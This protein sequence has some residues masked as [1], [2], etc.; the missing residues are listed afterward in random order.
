MRV[1]RRWSMLCMLALI[2]T[3]ANAQKSPL[4][5]SLY[6]KA[7]ADSA[8]SEYLRSA[9]GFY[10]AAVEETKS[11]GYDAAFSAY[12]YYRAGFLFEALSKFE[13]AHKAYHLS[14]PYFRKAGKELNVQLTLRIIGAL[15]DKSRKKGIVYDFP[16]GPAQETINATR[17]IDSLKQLPDKTYEAVIDGGTN[18]GIYEGADAEVY[19]KHISGLD[20]SNRLLGSARITEVY[21][22]YS[23]AVIQLINPA[24]SFYAIYPKD[25]ITVPIR[26]PKLAFKDVFLEVSLMNIRFVDN[27]REWIAH[28]RTMMYYPSQELEKDIYKCML[29]AIEEIYEMIKDDTTYNPKDVITRGRLKGITWKQAMSRSTPEDLKAFLGFVR[30]YPGKYMG[31]VWK[32]SETY[33][34]WLLNNAPPGS[35]EIMDSLMAAKTDAEFL[36]YAKSYETSIRDNF[37]TAWQVDAQNMAFIDRFDEALKWNK[38]LQRVAGVYNDPDMIGWSLFN[39]GRIQDE[40]KKYDDALSSYS[41]AKSYFEKGKD[42]RGLSFCINNLG[43]I[44]GVKYM[45]KESELMYEQVLKLRL[46]R[47]LQDS[48]DEQR[49][50]VARAYWGVGDALYNQS[51]YKEAIDQY[52]KGLAVLAKARSLEARKQTATINRLMG[53]SYEKM[54]DYQLAADCYE[55][56]FRYQKALGDVEAEADAVDN[57]AYLLSKVGKYRDAFEKY[58]L[59]YELHL[60]SGEKND[61]GFSMSNIGQVLWSLGKFDSAIDA[62]NRAI[63]LRREIGNLKGEAYSW[64]KIGALYKESGDATRSM[65]AYER[66]LGLYK[67]SEAREEY[68]ELLEDIASN[69]VKIK[70][71]SNADKYYQQALLEYRSIKARD[72]EAALLSAIGN[73]F[74]EERNYAK[75]DDY[76]VQAIAIQQEIS[77]K[78]GLMYNYINRALVSQ[79]YKED[80]K[81]AIAKM[82]RGLLLAEET[83]SEANIAYCHKEIGSLYS[84]INEYDSALVL[85]D[86]AM[87]IY[88][89]LED[90]E[91]QAA[92]LIS[93]GYY[94]NYRGDFERGREQFEQSLALARQINNGY[95]IASAVYGLMSYHY[96]L[97]N[98]PEAMNKLS[99]VLKIYE[100]KQNPWGIASVYLDLGN[101][102]NQQGEFD[103]ALMYYRKTDSIY[104]KLSLE[105]PRISVA[106]NIGTIYYHQKNY[107]EALKQFQ[108]TR[109]M[110]EKFNDDPSFLALVRSNIGEV[111]LDQKKYN[112]AEK[113][114]K[115]SLQMANQQKNNR[116]LYISNHIYG[117]LMSAT[118]N[119]SDAEKHFR[120]ADSLLSRGGEKTLV[121]QLL[122][123]WGEMLYKNNQPVEAEKKLS[124]CIELS[125]KTQYRNY[126]WKAYA[127]LA[128]IQL[129]ANNVDDG[130]DRLKK[131][132][133][134]VEKIKS[135]ITGSEAKKIFSSDESV[136]EL[137]QKM[138]LYLK[139]QGRVEEALV[140]MEKANAENIKLRLNTGDINYADAEKT[141]AVAKEK[142]LRK[143]QTLFENQ[144]AKE[145]SKPEQLQHKEQIA[146]WEKMRSIAA[147]QYKAYV[148]ELKIKYPHLAAFKTVDPA[149]FM[150]QRRRIPADVVV[151]SYLVTE[152]EMS[153]FV[154][155]RD[156]IFIKDIP[157]DRAL[158]QEKIK[159]FYTLHARSNRSS[160]DIRGGKLGTTAQTSP[161][162][163]EDKAQLAADLYQLLLSPFEKDI[164]GKQRVAIVP[165]GFL[166]FV[167]FDALTYKDANGNLHYFGEEKQLFYV[168]KI[169]TVTSGVYE[170]ITE[171]RV[172]AVGNADK[173]L[174]NAEEEVK[175]LQT[176]IP[177][178][179]VYIREQATK[180]NVLGNKGDFNILHLATHGVLDY[181]NADSSYLVLASD[182]SNNDDGKL[183]IAQIQSITDIDRFRLVT[184]SACETAVIREVAEGWPIST[185]SAF[186]EMG[187]PTVIATL[188]QVDDKAT[189]LLIDK[190]Y[191]NLKTMDKVQALQQAQAYLRKQP[192]YDDPYYWAPFQLV[193]LWK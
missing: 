172:M 63:L 184:L 102:R 188:W 58:Q 150:A 190:F 135:K 38:I 76:Y 94:Y 156:T 10:A 9:E 170:P 81:D 68:A 123:A 111:L 136:V 165:S 35:N 148:N 149:E 183:T 112:E 93:Y 52:S 54:G 193:G 118:K 192:G 69:Y 98:F 12:C 32:I 120:I 78:S 173:T 95:S 62:H 110:L 24:D 124:S 122:Q 114:L 72:K 178:T 1:L 141:E 176:K 53:K 177:Q 166:C 115:E 108:L 66:A 113:W 48:S 133:E 25:M 71:Y 17:S 171:F 5:K 137:Y 144:I 90:K 159:A 155:M 146:Q 55:N 189:R 7:V 139:K 107:E 29:S 27:S 109:R 16:K 105:K 2:L 21:P 104:Q 42:E 145:K 153:V 132:I 125:D 4:A 39:L 57:Q 65:E 175:T 28:P 49:S 179:V 84:Y 34:T 191:D 74:Y 14:L 50:A 140:Y 117:R 174:P 15:Y 162:K 36:F 85:Y 99:E 18:D 152:R 46:G 103:D 96:T 77:D 180:K 30:S 97:G 126:A 80:Y 147:E 73:R 168:N 181:S 138:V 119:Y 127:T 121:I 106:N 182:P 82:R 87:A 164:T 160:R 13:Q 92:L 8:R 131:A 142:E 134:E 56:E 167:P 43:Y 60:K 130:I 158:L 116:Q 40:Q 151:V 163:K 11:T 185:A 41:K 33:A 129:A 88:R 44:Y 3:Q 101:V 157:I 86:K 91:K 128:D 47:L 51:K 22:D 79:F 26:F 23:K 31:G 89:K 59:A 143:Q 100:E 45:Y 37:F 20:R 70:D 83:Q 6:E 187:V 67:K 61:A 186:I 19:G 169:S 64:K 161:A 75:A 154:V